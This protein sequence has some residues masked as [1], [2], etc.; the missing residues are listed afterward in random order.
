MDEKRGQPSL[1][2]WFVKPSADSADDWQLAQWRGNH[3]EARAIARYL[4]GVALRPGLVR[5]SPEAGS[6]RR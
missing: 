5:R 6:D 4:R 1:E 3:D 2:Q